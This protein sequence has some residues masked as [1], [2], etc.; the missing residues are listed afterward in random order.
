MVRT[1]WLPIEVEHLAWGGAV[2]HV[3]ALNELFGRK[4]RIAE[5]PLS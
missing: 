1:N 2:V 5:K 3:L 4:I